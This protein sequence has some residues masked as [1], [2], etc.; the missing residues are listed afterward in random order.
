MVAAPSWLGSIYRT[1]YGGGQGGISSQQAPLVSGAV[2]PQPLPD[3]SAG[4]MLSQASKAAQTA[5]VPDLSGSGNDNGGTGSMGNYTMTLPDNPNNG[6]PLNGFNFGMMDDYQ[7]D[8]LRDNQF[9]TPV[10]PNYGIYFGNEMAKQNAAGPSQFVGEMNDAIGGQLNRNADN[11]FRNNVLSAIMGLGNNNGGNRVM[12]AG[13]V[14]SRQ[15]AALPGAGP[16]NMASYGTTITASAPSSSAVHD[17]GSKIA[18]AGSGFKLPQAVPMSGAQ[19]GAANQNFGHQLASATGG[20]GLDFARNANQQAQQLGLGIASARANQGNALG[21]VA[22][23][24][25]QQNV[26]NAVSRQGAMLRALSGLGRL[27]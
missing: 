21:N 18:S 4:N 10:I 9:Q 27:A 17:A 15:F 13:D 2:T 1:L 12:G 14:N 23:N 11:N 8:I 5:A 16:G 7:G 6:G 3:D 26:Q 22:Q 25:N 19:Y 20:A 24:F